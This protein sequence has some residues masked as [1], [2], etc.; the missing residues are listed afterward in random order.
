VVHV[1]TEH[2]EMI[3]TGIDAG[4]V[5]KLSIQRSAADLYEVV[6]LWHLCARRLELCASRR[7]GETL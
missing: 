1:T 2:I 4:N 6:V 3:G 5:V 7:A